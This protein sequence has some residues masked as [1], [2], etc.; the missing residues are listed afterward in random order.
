[1][2]TTERALHE[3]QS[4]IEQTTESLVNEIEEN[5]G[6]MPIIL[7][8]YERPSG[9][10][11]VVMFPVGE[12]FE[13]E[14]GKDLLA[15][16]IIPNC[17]KILTKDKNIIHSVAFIHEAWAYEL[18]KNYKTEGKTYDQM[19]KD[20]KKTEK[21]CMS[22]HIEGGVINY[23]YDMVRNGKQ[24]KLTNKKISQTNYSDNTLIGRFS[25]LM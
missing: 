11:D 2:K 9:E 8:Q 4:N 3:I 10:F 23:V 5:G 14:E 6:M 12:L 24:L 15:N 7:I 13:S 1:M 16:D 17:K 18:P 25:K 20:G 19:R 21:L 22:F